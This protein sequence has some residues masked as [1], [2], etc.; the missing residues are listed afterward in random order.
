MRV[1]RAEVREVALSLRQPFGTATAAYRPRRILLVRV[2]ADE[3]EGWGE[4]AADLQPYA[5]PETVESAWEDLT[6]ILLPSVV[7]RDVASPGQV[8]G[9]G[10]MA[11]A[12]AETALWDARARADGVPL[13]VAL[14]GSL[15]AVPARAVLG[16]SD[17]S[18]LRAAVGQALD[19]GYRAIKIKVA[20]GRDRGLVEAVRAEAGDVDLAVDAN[21][22]YRPGADLTW[23]DEYAITYVEQ[24][25]P[26]GDLR[27]TAHLRTILRTPVCLDEDVRSV[28][29]ASEAVEQRAADVI[30]VKSGRLGGHGSALAVRDLARRAGVGTVAGGL[31]E[32]GIGRAHAVALATTLDHAAADLSGSDRYYETD[33]TEPWEIVDGALAPSDRPGIGVSVDGPLLDRLTVRRHDVS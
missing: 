27:A 20:P 1:Q 11:R 29:D 5:A 22:S 8:R 16:L 25:L 31:L 26:A 7:G 32:T 9:G 28:D 15:R 2:W 21:G 6:T 30:N 13:A 33:L 4:C 14:G 3:H 17:P 24:P 19:D 23:L 10:P 18:A 12:A